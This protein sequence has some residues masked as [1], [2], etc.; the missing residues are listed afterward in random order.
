M[1][2]DMKKNNN[3]NSWIT[4]AVV[5][6]VAI[7]AAYFGYM[8]AFNGSPD[9]Q[10]AP[11][12]V[13][14]IGTFVGPWGEG[15]ISID[16]NGDGVGEAYVSF[17]SKELLNQFGYWTAL[18]QDGA[19]FKYLIPK[20]TKVNLECVSHGVEGYTCYKKTIGSNALV[21]NTISPSDTGSEGR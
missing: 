4:F 16:V 2:E 10:P 1:K 19:E 15:M 6:V 11:S 8:F 12:L 3:S 14:L 13:T 18:G 21:G 20:G 9:L 17:D 7:V 5:V